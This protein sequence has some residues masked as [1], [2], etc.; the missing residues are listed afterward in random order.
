MNMEIT[1]TRKLDLFQRGNY[2]DS[3]SS[4]DEIGEYLLKYA[5]NLGIC[6]KSREEILWSLNSS[7]YSVIES[8][9]LSFA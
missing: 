2:V 5:E 8:E 6:G 1:R 7:K 9:H 3:F 4:M